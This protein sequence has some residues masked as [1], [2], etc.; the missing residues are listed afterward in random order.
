MICSLI[1]RQHL[2][3]FRCRVETQIIEGFNE[4]VACYCDKVK[5]KCRQDN[6]IKEEVS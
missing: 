1:L 2:E 6:I 5:L 3:R 4:Y